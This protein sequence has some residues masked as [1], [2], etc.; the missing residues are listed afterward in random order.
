MSQRD[1]API[2]QPWLQRYCDEFLKIAAT[3]PD[4]VMKD[5][6]LRRVECVMDVLDAWQL[7][8]IPIDQ[9]QPR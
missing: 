7:R 8:N 1:R 6:I 2:D 4:G 9:R 5:T 3:M